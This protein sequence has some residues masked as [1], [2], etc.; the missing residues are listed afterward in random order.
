MNVA[1]GSKNPIKIEA[2]R[3]A[4]KTVW[5]KIAW[6]VVGIEVASGVSHQPMSSAEAIHGAGTRARSALALSEADYSVGMEGGFQRIGEHGFSMGWTV[7]KDR[8][9]NIGIG[10]SLHTLL[11]PQMVAMIENGMELGTVD[12]KIFGRTNSKQTEGFIGLMTNGLITRTTAYR[13]GVIAALSRF[14]H[15]ELFTDS[16]N[17]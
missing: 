3:L 5:P 9:G 2:V 7:V 1:V 6:N 16:R 12:D 4:F 15:A 14:L 10:A 8:Q 11:P 13:D 17:S